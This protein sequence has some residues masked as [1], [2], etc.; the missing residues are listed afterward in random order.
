MGIKSLATLSNSE[1]FEAPKPLTKFLKKLKH[2]Q[3]SLA[4]RKK[5]SHNRAKLKLKIAQVHAK[6][7][8]IRQD[9]LH[10]LT[11]FLTNHFAGIV[12]EDLNVK[13]MLKNRKLSRA[14]ADLGFYEFRRQLKYKT[15]L[16]GNYLLIADRWFPSSKTCSSCGN[17]KEKLKL[18]ERVY[19]CEEGIVSTLSYIV[20]GIFKALYCKKLL[21]PEGVEFESP[22]GTLIVIH[23]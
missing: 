8:K 13:G 9:S 10:K 1:T 2:I 3:R 5:D 12:I 15:Q 4:R 18:S 16:K 23:K 20:K 19:H 21:N 22:G 17:L 14:I 11:T 6:I 7:V